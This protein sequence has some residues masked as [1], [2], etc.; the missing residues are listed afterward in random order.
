MKH[1]YIALIALTALCFP[2]ASCTTLSGSR[3]QHYVCSYDVVW[4]AALESVKGRSLQA[5]DKTKGLIETNWLEMEGRERPYGMFGREGFGNKE[6]SR[7]T[8]TVKQLDDM[9]AVSVLETRQRWHARGGV[10]QQATKWWPIEPSEEAMAEV[11]GRLNS[12]LKEK[13]CTAT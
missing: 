11:V 3:D 9:T 7:L 2:F 4:D 5:E 10:T 13:G 6:R 1:K 12:K 8:V